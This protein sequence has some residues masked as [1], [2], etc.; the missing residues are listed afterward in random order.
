MS[1]LMEQQNLPSANQM[2]DLLYSKLADYIERRSLESPLLIGIHSGGAWL[3]TRLH[4]KMVDA[5]LISDPLGTLDISFYRDDFTRVGLN[6]KVKP[7]A[8]PVSTQDRNIILIDDVLMSGRTV[9]AAL[10]VLFEVGRPASVT[11]AVLIDLNANELPIKAD[12]A[13]HTLTLADNQ[14]IKLSGPDTLKLE[15][16]ELSHSDERRQN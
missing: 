13:A 10:N 11:L 9:R 3:A 2:L 1:D 5:G 4:H 16:Q 6:P 12:V 14:R 8:L 15:I 7:S